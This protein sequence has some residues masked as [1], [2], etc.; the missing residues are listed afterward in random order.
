MQS[1]GNVTSQNAKQS[2]FGVS[3]NCELCKERIEKTAKSVKNKTE[4]DGMREAHIRDGVAMVNF[5]YWFET[6]FGKKRITELTVGE[7]LKEFRSEQA[8]FMGES[9]SPIVGFGHHGAIVHYIATKE[10]EIE[11]QP[12]GI[13]LFDTG[14]QYLD[15]TT[16]ITRTIATGKITSKQQSDFTLVLKGNIQLAKAIFP[17]N[18]KGYSLDTLARKALWSNG[19]NYGHGTGHGVGHYLCVHEGPMS[20]RPEYNGEPIREGQIITNEPG[21]YREGEYGI[22]IENVMVCKKEF[23]SDFGT[24]LSF[25]TLTMCPIDRKLVS[26][27]LLADDEIT[28]L[29]SYHAKVLTELGSRLNPE[30][31]K[32]LKA[33]CEPI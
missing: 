22:R 25:D 29:N 2:S 18:T 28:W 15:G 12:D 14:G 4:T 30:V 23:L 33:Q 24:F 7:K 10:T 8:N 17:E 26:R 21:I 1:A 9:F 11:I 13:L 3:G 5:L 16:D 19:L 31:L 20:I 27:Q 6:H 32:W